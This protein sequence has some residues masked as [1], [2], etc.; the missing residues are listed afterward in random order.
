MTH[1]TKLAL[2]I[3]GCA[4]ALGILGDWLFDSG[5]SGIR[6]GLFVL[7]TCLV[8]AGLLRCRPGHS[9]ASR[10]VIFLPALFFS[11]ALAWRDSPT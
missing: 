5:V 9:C 11:F 2:G 3:A 8:G 7:L 1:R 10:G 4:G 6:V